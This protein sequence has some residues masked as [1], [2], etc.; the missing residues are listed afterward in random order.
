MPPRTTERRTVTNLKTKSNQ[1]CQK[2]ELYGSLK[3]LKKKYSF[4]LVRRVETGS[5]GGDDVWQGS[6][7][8]TGRA[9]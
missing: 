5:Q 4:R 7:C 1:K 8:R 2:I 3:E 6:G 9:R